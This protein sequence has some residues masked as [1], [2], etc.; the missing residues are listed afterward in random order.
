MLTLLELCYQIN[1]SSIER[2]RSII[3]AIYRASTQENYPMPLPKWI[4]SSLVLYHRIW[5]L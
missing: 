3:V 2:N 4:P 5:I 1:F